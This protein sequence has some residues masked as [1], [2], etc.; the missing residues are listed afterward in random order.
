MKIT[1]YYL[2]GGWNFE[3]NFE[4]TNDNKIKVTHIY[5]NRNDAEE[6]AYTTEAEIS[7]YIGE[8]WYHGIEQ[9][10]DWQTNRLINYL[11]DVG[12]FQEEV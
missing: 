4:S 9:L 5:D 6:V 1:K 8:K 11:H 10:T 3:V 7:E 12:K 2:S